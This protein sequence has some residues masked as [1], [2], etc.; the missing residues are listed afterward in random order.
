MAGFLRQFGMLIDRHHGRN[1]RLLLRTSAAYPWAPGECRALRHLP[2]H[3]S[4]S[5]LRTVIGRK[6]AFD[7]G[8]RGVRLDYAVVSRVQ[9]E[10]RD[11]GEGSSR[12]PRSTTRLDPDAACLDADSKSERWD[13]PVWRRAARR[14]CSTRRISV[15]RRGYAAR[16]QNRGPVQVPSSASYILGSY[17]VVLAFSS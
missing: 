1:N 17:I 2:R 5:S 14:R 8:D 13:R 12:G 16:V 6:V 4:S 11:Q 3:P 9:E 10:Q 7:P 15:V